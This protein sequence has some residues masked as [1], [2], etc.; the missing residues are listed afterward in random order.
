M[1]TLSIEPVLAALAAVALVVVV[2]LVTRGRGTSDGDPDG[3][4]AGH[5][6]SMLS[7]LFLLIFAIAVII[8]WTTADEAERNT[9]VESQGLVEAYW[10]AEG[11][12]EADRAA[13]RNEIRGYIDFVVREEWPLMGRGELSPEG[14][15]R[16]DAIRARL[17]ALR[18]KDDDASDA[19]A[20]TAERIREVYAAR[21]Q[22][23][24][25]AASGLPAGVLFFMVLTG[26]IMIVFPFMVGAR[27]RGMTLAALGVMAALL[28]VGMY[29]VFDIDQAFSGG[30]GVGPEAFT[31]AHQEISRVP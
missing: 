6:G 7:A 19:R 16:L 15:R 17:A 18:L 20:D 3:A 11:L 10:R 14:W 22:R 1:L 29:L 4:T 25:D 5:A 24:S 12:P 2:A 21:R 31:D 8:P 27:P 23:A 28:G 30:L 26:V 13:V 9:G